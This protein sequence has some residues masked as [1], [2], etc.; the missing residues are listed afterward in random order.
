[1]LSRIWHP[2]NTSK[3]LRNIHNGRLICQC[4]EHISEWTIPSF[5][6]SIDGN[7][8]SYRA[9]AIHQIHVFLQFIDTRSLDRDLFTGNVQ[10][11][12]NFSNFFKGGCVVFVFRFGL[13]KND[14]TNIAT[15]FLFRFLGELFQLTAHIQSGH[16]NI[17]LATLICN[18]YWKLDHILLLEPQCINVAN[19]VTVVSWRSSQIKNK[20]GVEVAKHVNRQRAFRIVT[21]VNN[22][23]R[24]QVAHDIDKSRWIGSFQ[25]LNSFPIIVQE[26]SQI[27]ILLECLSV[28]LIR[29]FERVKR[30]HN[31]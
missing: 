13:E 29:R 5:F 19:D 9:I 4:R 18:N 26:G 6:E 31:D 1:M 12:K 22:H 28:F 14:R 11:K 23:N 16:N 7:D 20:T 2:E 25:R 10:F 8:V 17:F 30:H 15:T 21:F 24:L 27:A 3:N